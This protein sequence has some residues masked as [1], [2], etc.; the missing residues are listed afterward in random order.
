MDQHNVI[1]IGLLLV[2]LTAG[3]AV[4]VDLLR[5]AR[6]PGAQK[7]GRTLGVGL[8]AVAVLALAACWLRVTHE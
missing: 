6:S 4:G 7:V 1:R 8:P 3:L 5:E 2:C